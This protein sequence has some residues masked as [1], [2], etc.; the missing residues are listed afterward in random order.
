M[1]RRDFVRCGAAGL[2]LALGSRFWK[3][4]YARPAEPGPGPY[5]PLVSEPDS[6]GLLLP[7][8]FSS[9]V[10][11]RTASLVPGTT[12]TWH[13]APDGGACFPLESG[14]WAYVSNSEVRFF[15]G[16]AVI[17]FDAAANIVAAR[18][19]LKGTS[20]NCAGGA[21]PWGTWLSCEEWSG[22]KVYEC[23]VEGERAARRSALGTFAHEAVAVDPVGRRLYLTEDAS[24]G[25]FYRF[26]PSRYPALDTGRLDAAF[27]K[28]T[29]EFRGEVTWAEVS[30]HFPASWN[31][32]TSKRTTAFNGGEGCFYDAGVV[33]FTT[34]GDNRV[35]A[36]TVATGALECIYA[37]ELY[38]SSPLR[39]VDNVIASRSGDLFVAEDGGDMELCL[40]TPDRM[41][42]P[43][44]RLTAHE[45]SEITG[46]GF[47]PA[48]DRLY[49][50]SQRGVRGAGIGVTFE[51]TGPFRS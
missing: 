36:L 24:N 46:P 16:A 44:L 45:G 23:R 11:A 38:P 4:A 31:P 25:R 13:A 42:S 14:G 22:G 18:T 28:W 19:I 20:L 9:R 27:V 26:T 12:H 15:G 33:Y 37:P 29:D 47:N 2:G 32:V 35:W 5:G 39:G 10:I 17:E 1:K 7:S 3:S 30:K 51:V 50:S 43:F 8:G 41:L 48:G 49:F 40:L 34:K 21:T 6:N